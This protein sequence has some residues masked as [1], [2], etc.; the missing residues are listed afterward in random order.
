M[1]DI[2][3]VAQTI[4]CGGKIQKC[5]GVLHL[6]RHNDLLQNKLLPDTPLILVRCAISRN[7]GIG[8]SIQIHHAELLINVSQRIDDLVP[9][10]GSG[11]RT[12][13][14]DFPLN[15]FRNKLVD[16]RNNAL[17]KCLTGSCHLYRGVQDPV[18]A[19]FS[20]QPVSGVFKRRIYLAVKNQIGIF[21]QNQPVLRMHQIY[22]LVVKFC[23]NLLFCPSENLQKSLADIKKRKILIRGAADIAARQIFEQIIRYL[24]FGFQLFLPLQKAAHIGANAEDRQPPILGTDHLALVHRPKPRAVFPRHAIGR[25]V[26]HALVKTP[27]QVLLYLQHIVGVNGARHLAADGIGK[28]VH[29]AITEHSRHFLVGVIQRKIRFTVS[30]DD[31][32]FLTMIGKFRCQRIFLFL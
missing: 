30:A 17:Q 29:T 3:L 8:L 14:L 13:Q 7:N 1:S 24:V 20:Q 26:G 5:L 4:R 28:L 25:F 2:G 19:V 15:F 16:I 6:L 12:L 22:K 10:F 18:I 9:L 11:K 27:A 23:A 31:A 21:L 32:G